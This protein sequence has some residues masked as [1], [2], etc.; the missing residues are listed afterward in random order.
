M[1]SRFRGNDNFLV[2]LGL[3]LQP[4]NGKSSNDATAPAP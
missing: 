2:Q 4:A 1:D 3:F